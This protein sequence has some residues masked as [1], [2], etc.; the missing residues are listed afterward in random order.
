M[1]ALRP[2]ERHMYMHTHTHLKE[3][4]QRWR[5]SSVVGVLVEHS[6]PQAQRVAAALYKAG[7][8]PV[9]NP[10]TRKLEAEGLEAQDLPC[11][12]STLLI[13]TANNI[14]SEFLST[15]NV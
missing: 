10:N 4:K 8:R 5:W 6:K 14:P 9:Y 15:I 7:V 1:C 2:R 3:E 12:R 13:Q 11:L